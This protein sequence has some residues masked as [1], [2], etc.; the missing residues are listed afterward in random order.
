MASEP[1]ETCWIL[2]QILDGVDHGE[3]IQKDG[4]SRSG[5]KMKASRASPQTSFGPRHS[6]ASFFF[7]FT[8]QTTNASRPH[9]EADEANLLVGVLSASSVGLSSSSS[10]D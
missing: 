5:T 3:I 6:I 2:P 1:F 9:E 4:A 10:I 8:C 7:S